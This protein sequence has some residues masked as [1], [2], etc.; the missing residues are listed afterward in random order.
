V[1]L[2]LGALLCAGVFVWLHGYLNDERLARVINS[3][4]N[5]ALRG[6][7]DLWRVHWRPRI[8]L[9]LVL[10][11]PTPVEIDHFAVYDPRG[12][13]VI[14]VPHVTAELELSPLLAGGN[15]IAHRVTVGQG[16]CMVRDR[17]G[18]GGRAEVGLI[19]AFSPMTPS[20]RPGS[21]IELLDLDLKHVHLTLDFAGWSLVLSGI[22]SGGSF[23]VTGRPSAEGSVRYNLRPNAP[24]GK[25]TILGFEVPL[26]DLRTKRFEVSAEKPMDLE[27]DLTVVAGGAPTRVQGRLLSIYRDP[28]GIFVQVTADDAQ[29]V[30]Y[31]TLG[32]VARGPGRLAATI[33]GPL[34]SPI[35]TGDLTEV[36]FGPGAYQGSG[37]HGRVVLDTRKLLLNATDLSGR[38]MGG[39]FQGAGDLNLTSGEWHAKAKLAGVHATP[40]HEALAGELRGEVALGGAAWPMPQA[41]AEMN[42]EL[43]RPRQ[44]L[45]PQRLRIGGTVHLDPVVVDLVGVT[46]EGE[47]NRL[48]VQGSMNMPARRVNLRVA[49]AAQHLGE[50]FARR[51]LVVA[52][53]SAQG[54]M[55]VTGRWPN[56]NAGGSVRLQRVG[57]GSLR[58]PQVAAEVAFSRGTLHFNRITSEG[59]GGRLAGDASLQIF[60]GDLEHPLAMPVLRVRSSAEGMDLAALGAGSHAQGRLSADFEVSGPVNR[61]TGTARVKLPRSTLFGDPYGPSWARIGVLGDRVSV[62]EAQLSR[63]DGGRVDLWGDV[64]F[65]KRLAL[66][67]S[68]RAFPVTGI[69]GVGRFP[70]GLGGLVSGKVDLS[71]T[72]S[73]P[74]I[75]GT[76]KLAGAKVRGITLGD[77]QVTLTPTSDGVQISGQLLDRLLRLQGYLLSKPQPRLQLIVDVTR[78]PIEKL[79]FEVRRLGDVRGTVSGR[80]RLD[81]DALRGL[82]SASVDFSEAQ[83]ALHHRPPGERR[84]RRITLSNQDALRA[85][86]DG[87]KLH[88]DQAK[89]VTRLEE[90]S[91]SHAE[92]TLGGWLSSSA[93]DMRLQGRVAMEIVEF[94]LAREVKKITGKA[95]ADVRLAG[96]MDNLTLD[97]K[98]SLGHITI[99]MPKFDRR[100]EIPGGDVRLLPGRLRIDGLSFRVDQSAAVVSGEVTLDRLRPS[101]VDLKLAGDLSARLLQLVFPE[102]VSHAAGAVRVSLVAKGPARDPQFAGDLAIKQIEMSP[103]G[104]GRTITLRRGRV[105][106]R[107][108]VVKTTEPLIGT[109]DEGFIRVSGEARLNEWDLANIDLK[110]IGAG[111]PQRQPKVYT[112]EANLN[113]NLSGDSRQLALEG[114]VELVDAKYV[115]PFEL[116][117]DTVLRPHAFEEETPIW[118]GRPLLENLQL[119]LQVLSTGQLSV[120]NNYA[121]LALSGALIVTGTLSAP[122]MSGQIRVEEGTFRLPFLRPEFTVSR[123]DVSFS[124]GKPADEAEINITGETLFLDRSGVDYQIRMTFLGP[125]KR[126]GL[127]LS[128]V[129]NLDQGQILALLAFGRTTEQLRSQITGGTDSSLSTGQAAGAAGAADAQVKQFTGELLSQIVED[130]LIKV[131]HLDLIRLEVGTE[132]AQI[133]ACKKLGRYVNLCGNYDYGLLGDTR[134]EGRMEIKMSDLLMLVAKWEKLSPRLET[135]TVDASRGRAE[136]KLRIPLR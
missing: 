30:L 81:V 8:V 115:R 102:Q 117:K 21:R 96:P 49:L 9:D 31:R 72:P 74:R 85:H 87:T 54:S 11:R 116:L 41:R 63:G 90:E 94:F 60:E 75:S 130:P 100:I 38:W 119:Q 1:V 56:L 91:A 61:L 2:C 125:L 76:V 43:R 134:A 97:G 52:A 58:V 84:E 93:A 95:L 19:A 28:K 121:S 109:Y 5:A 133:R 77:G 98:L 46:L 29:R 10:G 35:I 14:L 73:D 110:I 82:T 37:I 33:R 12:E 17:Q 47:G 120:K 66:R 101:T 67:V 27:H 34:A 123:G 135:D 131:T 88:V 127:Q 89:L 126:I 45:L 65:D 136:L 32:A 113:L 132:S 39:E 108:Y 80:V 25:L 59:Y 4:A 122:R 114:D 106:L 111:I 71:G 112:A 50:W 124:D 40:V 53:E 51:D 105:S 16:R 18:P 44:D 86:F 99:Q 69:P 15:L 57:Y 92:F 68:A 70:M 62:Y 48:T 26:S 6:R 64:F 129:P 104:L 103:R 23:V 36:Q 118:K 13:E 107:D 55:R 3:G 24:T 79:L 20:S 83:I 22:E 128:S 7:L 78:F 42:L